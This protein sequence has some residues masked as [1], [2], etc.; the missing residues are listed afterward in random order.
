M[1]FSVFMIH[2]AIKKNVLNEGEREKEGPCTSS[3]WG[4]G[5]LAYCE[6]GMF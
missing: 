5:T 2:F 3:T 4:W 1:W 6:L